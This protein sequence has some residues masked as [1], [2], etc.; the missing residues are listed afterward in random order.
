MNVIEKMKNIN[1]VITGQ[2]VNNE[3]E[4]IKINVLNTKGTYKKG[5]YKLVLAREKD[6]DMCS[7]YLKT[8]CD[9]V[10][11]SHCLLFKHENKHDSIW[12]CYIKKWERV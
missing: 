8:R 7:P 1:K 5:I 4:E 2:E 9:K 12:S 10:C 3:E 6:H 11:Y